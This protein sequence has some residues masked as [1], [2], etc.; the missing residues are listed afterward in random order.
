MH[1]KMR[2][3]E[4]SFAVESFFEVGW[5]SGYVSSVENGEQGGRSVHILRYYFGKSFVR[6]TLSNVCIS[7]ILV[8]LVKDLFKLSKW[9]NLSGKNILIEAKR[10]ALR[11]VL[12][13]HLDCPRTVLLVFYLVTS[14]F[15]SRTISGSSYWIL[16]SWLNLTSIYYRSNDL[17]QF[18]SFRLMVHAAESCLSPGLTVGDWNSFV[19]FSSISF[20][21]LLAVSL[22]L[23]WSS[24]CLEKTAC[25]LVTAQ[26]LD[27][28]QELAFFLH[29]FYS[30]DRTTYVTAFLTIIFNVG[31]GGELKIAAPHSTS[32][33]SLLLRALWKPIS[34]FAAASESLF[35]ILDAICRNLG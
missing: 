31:S 27:L 3:N 16:S 23:R 11:N 4:E 5:V 25:F 32:N 35:M 29:F 2:R 26:K 19:D 6:W 14:T 28:N 10:K 30:E 34:L 24:C 12:A 33:Q 8:C 21:Q 15:G 17:R 1:A 13:F 18:S 20:T 22:L 9:K 7:E